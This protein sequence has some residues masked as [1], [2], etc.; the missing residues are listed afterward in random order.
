[1]PNFCTSNV[2]LHALVLISC[3]YAHSSLAHSF[4]F[5][6]ILYLEIVARSLRL[7]VFDH[8]FDSELLGLHNKK[9]VHS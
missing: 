5:V 4:V 1:M 6:V 8:D 3:C 9:N 2:M 7:H